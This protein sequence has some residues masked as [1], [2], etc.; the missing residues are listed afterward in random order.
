M[1]YR[2]LFAFQ[3]HRLHILLLYML[4]KHVTLSLIANDNSMQRRTGFEYA[5]FLFIIRN[6]IN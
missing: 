4:P 1:Q 6:S 2:M 5:G 3:H